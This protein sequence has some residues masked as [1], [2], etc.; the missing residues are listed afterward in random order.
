MRE[1]EV[2]GIDDMSAG[3]KS[4]GDRKEQFNEF[5]SAHKELIELVE[6]SHEKF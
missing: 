3:V 5:L 2:K 1:S 6:K 4:V